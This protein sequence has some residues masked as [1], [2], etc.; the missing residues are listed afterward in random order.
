MVVHVIEILG[1]RER[2]EEREE[3]GPLFRR[4]LM[5]GASSPPEEVLAFGVLVELKR[6]LIKIFDQ[7]FTSYG[8]H[9]TSLFSALSS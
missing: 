5:A 3:N 6:L 9:Y 1:G 8:A 4:L 2:S 7:A